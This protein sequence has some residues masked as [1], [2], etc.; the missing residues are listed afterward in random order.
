MTMQRYPDRH[1]DRRRELSQLQEERALAEERLNALESATGSGDKPPERGI[2]LR[3]DALQ[4]EIDAIK[5]KQNELDE[6]LEA[7]EEE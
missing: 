3:I 5:D 4:D 7:L 1:D 2:A 6:R